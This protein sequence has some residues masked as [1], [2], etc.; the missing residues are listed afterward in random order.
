VKNV[1]AYVGENVVE[2]VV[3]NVEDVAIPHR[4]RTRQHSSTF[5]F[6]FSGLAVQQP[7]RMFTIRS[8]RK[9]ARGDHHDVPRRP[10]AMTRAS[11]NSPSAC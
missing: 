5:F 9:S 3:K 1:V 4:V 11:A 2:D 6:S 7:R 8:N 10:V